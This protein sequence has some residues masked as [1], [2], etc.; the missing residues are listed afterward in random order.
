M[1]DT[2][3]G[4]EQEFAERVF[5][6]FERERSSTMS[7]IQ[8]TGLGMAIT[9]RIVDLMG[10]KIE[11]DTAPG[12]GTAFIVHLQ[13]REAEKP[14]PAGTDDGDSAARRD[15]V[16]P[17][18]EEKPAGFDGMRLLIV[19]DMAVNR[20]IALMFLT[21]MGFVCD[22]AENGKEAVDI[23]ASSDH[24][25][26]H[27][28]LMDIQMPVMDG[29]EAARRIRALDSPYPAN[30]PIIAMSANAFAED[31]QASL[32]SGMNAHIAKPIDLQNLQDT[33]EEILLPEKR[34]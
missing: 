28:I 16:C 17:C 30:I 31:V 34:G 21:Q 6:A 9:K 8:G 27:G 15:G 14:V 23:I 26:Y 24:C 22:M 20:E 1:Q 5:E 19:D 3:I 7:G 4:M 13:F 33:L 2:G 29:Y 12:R 25:A 32:H 11:V 18:S 10:G